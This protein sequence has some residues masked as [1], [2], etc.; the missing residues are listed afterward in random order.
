[1][2]GK[3]IVE[4]K[5][6]SLYIFFML[7]SPQVPQYVVVYFSCGMW[8]A[9]SAWP[10]ECCHVRAQDPNQ[11]NPGPWKWR[12]WTL[13]TRPWGRPPVYTF[14]FLNLN[15]VDVLARQSF[16]SKKIYIYWK[17]CW[18]ERISKKL[19]DFIINRFD[20]YDYRV[21]AHTCTKIYA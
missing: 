17:H 16:Q 14:I 7:F 1:M 20:T 11:W 8:D 21:L 13:T 19:K 9:T 2:T 5:H 15:S 18:N 4:E 3:K 12:A 6:F 10:D